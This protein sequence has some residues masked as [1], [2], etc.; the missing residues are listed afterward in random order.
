MIMEAHYLLSINP[1]PSDEDIQTAMEGNLCRCTGY[2]AIRKAINIA[3]ERGYH[4]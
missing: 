2:K 4:S 3:V 1:S